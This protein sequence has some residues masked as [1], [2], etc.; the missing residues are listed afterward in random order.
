MSLLLLVAGAVPV[1]AHVQIGNY[2][3]ATSAFADEATQ[4]AGT[5]W[6]SGC[7]H[8]QTYRICMPPENGLAGYG[9]IGIDAGVH[10]ASDMVFQ[11]DF[12]DNVVVNQTGSDLVLFDAAFTATSGYNIAV[13]DSAG[14]ETF[15][16]FPPDRAIYAGI[17]DLYWYDF[18]GPHWA[19]VM[20]IEI[21]LDDFGIA[22]GALIT[23]I[24]IQ[25][26]EPTGSNPLSAAALHSDVVPA[27]SRTWGLI[28][29]LYR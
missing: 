17:S 29:S 4:V 22:P 18:H 11:L 6:T 10:I 27:E 14:F 16:A 23:S 9:G 15:I 3:L 26:T 19:G 21:E 8:R 13:G 5:P 28:K 1:H 2:T 12:I 7:F 20:A 24:R 25:A